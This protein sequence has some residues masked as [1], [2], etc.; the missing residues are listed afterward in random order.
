MRTP[1]IVAV[2]RLAVARCISV[3]GSM[4]AYAALIDLVYRRTNGSTIYLSLTVLLTIGAVGLLASLGGTLADR[5]DR[6]RVLIGSDLASALL[7]LVLAVVGAPWLLLA[8][9]FLTAVAETPFR[10]GSIAA[11]PSVVQ[12]ERLIAKANGWIS[13]GA[14]IGITLGPALGGI[15]VAWIGAAPVFV[16]NAISFVVSAA[17]VWSIDAPFGGSSIRTGTAVVEAGDAE[18]GALASRSFASGFRFLGRDRVLLVFTL[19]WMVLLLAM[20]VGIVADRPLADVFDAGSVGFGLMLGLW[21]LGSV[22]GSWAAGRVSVRT[23]PVIVVVGFVIAGAAGLVIGVARAFW[24]ILVANVLWGFGD[25]ATVVAEQGIIQRRTPD[26]I[27]ARVIGANE[28][29]VHTALVTGFLIASP[30]IQ[31]VGPQAA[32]AIMGA[33][34]LV[35]GVLASAVV[36]A[37]RATSA[38]VRPSGGAPDTLLD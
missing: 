9:A 6:K 37:A 10:T 36:G 27:R 25:A 29:L 35:A 30:T 5:A 21:G 17:L 16:L 2:R 3:T 38:R 1:P 26:A 23:E 22:A 34:A 7:F 33:A 15:L 20:G 31:G 13:V 4:A 24:V 12:D 14:N 18:D 8:V 32:Y 28:S 19:A 11:V